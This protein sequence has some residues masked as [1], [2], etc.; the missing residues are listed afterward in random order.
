MCDSVCCVCGSVCCVWQCVVLCVAV[1]CLMCSLLVWFVCLLFRDI[2]PAV[3]RNKEREKSKSAYD[4]SLFTGL[5]INN[6]QYR[7]GLVSY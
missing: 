5:V 6:I 4:P 7:I 1:C 3:K 2:M